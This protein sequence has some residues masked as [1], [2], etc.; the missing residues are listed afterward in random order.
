METKKQTSNKAVL[1]VSK[2]FNAPIQLVFDALSD[3]D[4]LAEWW[5]PVGFKMTVTQFNFA[6]DGLC[7]FKMENEG[8][9]MWAK[10]VYGQIKHPEL[11]EFVLSF[12]DE[13][14]KIIRAPFFKD[15]PLQI[16]NIITLTEQNGKTAFT[17]NCYPINAT[18]AELLSFT[19]NK[20][21]FNQGLSA[22]ME[23]LGQYLLNN[24]S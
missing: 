24:Q 11:V 8:T 16:Q 19:E 13:T 2:V 9:I 21:S 22:S 18:E 6:P 10:F 5:G 15:W 4:A 17:I 23:K 1:T 7:L 12:S 20:S 3:A 14:G